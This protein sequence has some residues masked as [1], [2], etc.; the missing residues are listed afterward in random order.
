M[1]FAAFEWLKEEKSA[2]DD[3][4]LTAMNKNGNKSS[5]NEINKALMQLEILGLISVR[6]I[7]KDKR[8]IEVIEAV[9]TEETKA[10]SG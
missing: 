10:H 7:G 4:L 5:M 6:W 1:K 3:E 9:V 2:T 8:R